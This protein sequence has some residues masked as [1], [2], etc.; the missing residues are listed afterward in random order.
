MPRCSDIDRGILHH[1][2]ML[3]LL[4]LA[5]AVGLSAATTAPQP[6]QRGVRVEL[7][8]TYHAHAVPA[9]DQ[10]DAL[11]VAVTRSGAVYLGAHP[12]PREALADRIGRGAAGS[13]SKTIYVKADA[14]ASS[15]AVLAVLDALRHA[16]ATTPVLLTAQRTTSATFPVPPFGLDI[17]TGP[18]APTASRAVVE[19]L[20]PA[21]QPMLKLNGAL[22]PAAALPSRLRGDKTVTVKADGRILFG[23]LVKVI[24][25]CHSAGA[26]VV[27]AGPDSGVV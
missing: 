21:R 16:G 7:A 27:L 18:A 4:L 6:L 20:P 22:I 10:P 5:T 2:A 19:V 24:D 17:Q 13:S 25:A 26:R 15:S 14:R 8:H 3:G 11:V 1:A 9:A 12:V 23:E